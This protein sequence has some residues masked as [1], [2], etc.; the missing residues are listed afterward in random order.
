MPDNGLGI[1][2]GRCPSPRSLNSTS[3]SFYP[4][5]LGL[6]SMWVVDTV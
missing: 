3:A 5:L 4:A 2:P 6:D 1:G